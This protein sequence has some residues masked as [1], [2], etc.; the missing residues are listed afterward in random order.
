MFIKNR[1]KTVLIVS[2]ALICIGE[3]FGLRSY[4]ARLN[5][6]VEETVAIVAHAHK[7]V[8]DYYAITQELD[9][10]LANCVHHPS[11]IAPVVKSAGK[12]GLRRPDQECVFSGSVSNGHLFKKDGT[13]CQ[14][15][16]WAPPR[17]SQQS[18]GDN[19]TNI[20]HGDHSTVVI[21]GKE[22]K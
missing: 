18:S 5:K 3:A 7:V 8:D 21:N 9:Y 1:L 22:G 20:V 4:Q 19:N 2:L 12:L 15:W 14:E 11:K 17:I 16:V 10:A 13:E 6:S